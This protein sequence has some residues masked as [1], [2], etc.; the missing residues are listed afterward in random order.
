MAE[1]TSSP[2][3]AA[4]YGS[5]A[6][7]EAALNALLAAGVPYET[8]HMGEHVGADPL[9]GAVSA[10]LPERFW[11]LAV[12]PGE[13]DPEQLKEKLAEHA[14]LSVG[15]MRS[16]E[17]ERS[18]PERGAVAWG[19]FVFDSPASTNQQPEASGTSGTTGIVSSGAFADGAHVQ[20]ERHQ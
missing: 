19:H 9:R 18:D 10:T 11:S 20:R 12:K 15:S 4:I 14:A 2:L 3:V 6:D 17:L 5:L 8:T 7:V 16:P 1:E 13:R